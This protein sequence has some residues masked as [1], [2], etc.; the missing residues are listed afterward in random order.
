MVW[1]F[2][3]GIFEV[4]WGWCGWEKVGFG[5][6][7]GLMGCQGWWWVCMMFGIEL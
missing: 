3:C 6:R 2:G 1:G 7:L 4:V 5:G